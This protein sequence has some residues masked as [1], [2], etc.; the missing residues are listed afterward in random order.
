MTTTPDLW[1]TPFIDNTTLTGNQD[2][3]VVA[4]TNADQF[5]AVWVDQNLNPDEIIA[6]KFDIL[7]NPITGEV[8]LDQNGDLGGELREPAA[9]R[10]PISGQADGLAV[11]FTDFVNG[12]DDIFL[13]R[14]DSSPVEIG[15]LIPI[16]NTKG[17]NTDHPSITSFKDGSLW[18]SYT[19]ITN[20]GTHSDIAAQRVDANGNLVGTPIAIAVASDLADNSD[21]ATLVNGNVVAVFQTGPFNNHDVFFTI[22]QEDGTIVVDTTGVNG[23]TDGNAIKP[24]PVVIDERDA[25]VA[26]LAD[27]GFVVTW[28]DAAGDGDANGVRASVYAANGDL[29]QGNILVN[30]FNQAS[31]QL[32][33]DVTALP[34]GGFIVAFADENPGGPAAVER[35]QRF[36]EAGNL[37][38]TPFTFGDF[39]LLFLPK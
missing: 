10:L 2:S 13:I 25:H 34:D 36:D 38:G 5:F 33:S 23:A 20:A 8:V 28:T 18:V 19:L 21:L 29:V 12:D 32:F 9:V 6:R 39:G 16:E 37:V 1:R 14:A 27:G 11:A 30:V 24:A 17:L 4:A 3:G 31:D 26:A 7:G 22:R 35:A 15:D